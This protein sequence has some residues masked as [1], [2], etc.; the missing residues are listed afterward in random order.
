MPRGSSTGSARSVRYTSKNSEMAACWKRWAMPPVT[1]P[2]DADLLPMATGEPSDD[3]VCLHVADCP[4]CRLRLRRLESEIHS[5]RRVPDDSLPTSWAGL[6]SSAARVS[7]PE[8]SDAD[9]EG[10]NCWDS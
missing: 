6:A 8:E 10:T 4:T 5:L 3:S 2:D 9:S 1:C 7:G